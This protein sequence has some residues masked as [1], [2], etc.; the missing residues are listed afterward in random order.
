MGC[1]TFNPCN[2]AL[3]PLGRSLQQGFTLIEVMISI[4][5]IAI[6]LGIGIPA[7]GDWIQNRQVNVLAESIGNGLRTAQAEAVQRNAP[8]DMVFTTSDVTVFIPADA[9]NAADPT[10]VTLTSGGLAIADRSPNWLVRVNGVTT[11]AGFIQG[12]MAQD[13]SENARFSGPAGVSF[14]PLGRLN[15]SIAVNGAMTVPAGNVVFR[16]LNP[17]VKSNLANLRCVFVGIG[18][19]VRICDPRATTPD[20]RACVPPLATTDC[21][22]P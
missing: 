2:N 12:K 3:N 9:T 21:P 10:A 14:S 19:A 17:S 16:V 20:A 18:G 4:A 6:F 13:G 11:G 8:V 5:I 7:I 1:K 15:A 22:I